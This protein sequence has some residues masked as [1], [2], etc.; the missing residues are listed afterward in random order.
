M[1][2]PCASRHPEQ[3]VQRVNELFHDYVNADYHEALPEIFELERDRWRALARDYLAPRP[4]PATAAPRTIME[5]GTGTGFVPLTIA[6][7]LLPSDSFICTD[8]SQGILDVARRNLEAAP[9]MTRPCRFEFLKIERAVPLRLPAAS[10][11]IDA[12]LMNSVLHHVGDT[13]AFLCEIDRVLKP[14]GR[15]IIAHEPN[16]YFYEHPLLMANWRL[17]HAIFNFR[18]VVIAVGRRW[19]VLGPLRRLYYLFRPGLRGQMGAKERYLEQLA[20]HLN[21]R[22]LAEGLVARPLSSQAILDLVDVR[23]GEGFHPDRL[24]PDWRLLH[25]ET[26]H[27]LFWVTVYHHRRRFVRR[28]DGWLARRFPRS[29]AT[30]AVVYE[31]PPVA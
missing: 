4:G 27:H 22:L 17:L 10:A 19:G 7:L 29:G 20:A 31:K 5:L 16:R 8:L 30:F 24:L 11:S 25:L 26:Y 2:R 28:F 18:W 21:E 1:S 3:L 14:G 6:P 15:V 23:A 9:A 12:I 13:D